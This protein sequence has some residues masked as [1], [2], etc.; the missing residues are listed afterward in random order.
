MALCCLRRTTVREGTDAV[1]MTRSKAKSRTWSA[2]PV[3]QYEAIPASAKVL[4]TLLHEYSEAKKSASKAPVDL[5]ALMMDDGGE[6]WDDE[7][8]AGEQLD[9]FQGTWRADADLYAAGVLDDDMEL[10]DDGPLVNVPG[11]QAI[12]DLDREVRRA[13]DPG[14]PG[15]VLPAADGGGL[16]ARA[17]RAG[18]P[19]PRGACDPTAVLLVAV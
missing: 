12:V 13:A 3:R 17:G 14:A 9:L 19:G 15:L 7:D 1:I 4:K 2:D 5:H 18:V 8:E 16:A 10:H 11:T 6:D